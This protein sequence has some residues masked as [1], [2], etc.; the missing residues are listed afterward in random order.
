VKQ[1]LCSLKET[2]ME[3][4]YYEKS[5]KSYVRCYLCAHRC[6]INDGK[7]GI[8]GVRE[9]RGGILY[10][11]I[12][13]KLIAFHVDPIEKKPLFHFQPG[14]LSFSVSTVGCNFSCL[15]CQNSDISQMPKDRNQILGENF[16]PQQIVD[17]AINKMCKSIS[18]TYTEPTIFM[19]YAYDIAVIASKRGIKNV[20]VTNGY[21]TKEIME[22]VKPF[23]HAANVDLKSFREEFYRKTC[24]AKLAPVLEAIKFLKE[25]GMWIEVTTLIIPSH[26]DTEKELR[27][28]A[29]F[30]CSIDPGIPWHISA[31]HP[32]YKMIQV[33][34]TPLSIIM[35]AREIGFEEGL[36]YVYSGNVPGD[37]GESTY[38][39][40]CKKLLIERYGFS[41]IQN[42]IKECRCP[43][44]HAEING[45]EM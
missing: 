14:N 19:E 25:M 16:S 20:L 45:V 10:S 42:L 4:R 22:Q 28:I 36:R 18:Y 24:K 5:E 41:V 35:R 31:F 27:E 7:A 6:K 32:T 23:F 44:C 33:S 17:M 21:M 29:R 15:H 30:I 2:P 26:N 12:Y 13:G 34:R 43:S 38:C 39:F 1:H 8:C 40:N 11:L 37:S 9:N 3:A